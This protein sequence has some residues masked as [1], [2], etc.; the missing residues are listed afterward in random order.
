MLQLEESLDASQR[1]LVGHETGLDDSVSKKDSFSSESHSLLAWENPIPCDIFEQYLDS[2][3][4]LGQDAFHGIQVPVLLRL[5]SMSELS[6]GLQVVGNLFQRVAL[7]E[8]GSMDIDFIVAALLNL[9][10][11]GSTAVRLQRTK[12]EFKS[13]EAHK[14]VEPSLAQDHTITINP[15]F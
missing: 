10:D 11:V 5:L 4:R 13:R 14:K 6:I 8:D 15:L 3:L 1:W 7:K 12:T 9:H 2:L